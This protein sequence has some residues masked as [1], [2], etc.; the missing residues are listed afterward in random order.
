MHI[1]LHIVAIL[2]SF[3]PVA[4]GVYVNSASYSYPYHQHHHHHLL[5]CFNIIVYTLNYF[6]CIRFRFLSHCAFFLLLFLHCCQ[7]CPL[8]NA[9]SLKD[10]FE[11]PMWKDV[12]VKGCAHKTFFYCK[13]MRKCLCWL[14][15]INNTYVKLLYLWEFGKYIFS[16]H[17]NDNCLDYEHWFLSN[18][19]I[20]E[21]RGGWWR[22]G[23]ETEA[24]K[25]GFLLWYA[26]FNFC[27]LILLINLSA[28]GLPWWKIAFR[29]S[30][31]T[32]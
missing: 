32:W 16:S 17:W 22:G 6:H 18:F 25:S 21:Y 30:A 3:V 27:Y 31:N 29:E 7:V 19:C 11:K 28:V 14:V 20:P 5:W 1:K 13:V 8:G 24:K 10:H 12:N 9:G 26:T 15:R 4:V 23:D 2:C